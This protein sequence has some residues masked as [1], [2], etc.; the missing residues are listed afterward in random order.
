VVRRHDRDEMIGDLA[1]LDR[2]GHVLA[3]VR[4]LLLR[5]ISRAL[6]RTAIEAIARRSALDRIDTSA[7]RAQ[8]PDRMRTE[9][10]RY[11]ARRVAAIVGA[12]EPQIAAVDGLRALGLDSLMAVELRDQIAGELAVDLPMA[13]LAGDPSIDELARTLEA[14]LEAQPLAAAPREEPPTDRPGH[15]ARPPVTI[16]QAPSAWLVPLSTG[17]GMRLFALPH[18]GGGASAFQPWR[19]L[20]PAHVEAHA[21]QL[22]GRESRLNEPA[23]VQLDAIVEHVVDVIAPRLDR[24]FVLF[25]ASM[26]GLCAFEIARALRRRGLPMPARL[27]IAAC[28][29]PHLPSPLVDRADA[30]RAAFGAGDHA[31]GLL[32]RDLGMLPAALLD[33]PD[34]LAVALGAI[35]ADLEAVLTHRHREQPPLPVD[36]LALG[37]RGDPDVPRAALEAWARHVSG[38]FQLDEIDGPHL[39][40][41]THAAEVMRLLTVAL[42][43]HRHDRLGSRVEG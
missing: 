20:M 17:S 43:H 25:G 19:E 4:G 37:G 31:A 32:L 41:R 40:Y 13:A 12:T 15:A 33:H 34:A 6:M 5:R 1:M 14:R 16:A 39:F 29:A 36:L 18:G 8:G 2:D 27:V 35:R 24:P 26:G 42:S 23:L 9:I 11:L 10:L 22:P 7:W 38:R 30:M 28:P 3:T 21:V